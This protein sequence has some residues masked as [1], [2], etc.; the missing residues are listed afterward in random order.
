[1]VQD[2]NQRAAKDKHNEA[3]QAL[4]QLRETPRAGCEAGEE[5]CDVCRGDEVEEEEG[6]E[7]EGEEE[8][9]E[10]TEAAEADKS[11][12]EEMRRAFEQQQRERQAPQ[13]TLTQH[14]QQE[15]GDVE[16]LRRQLAQWA[17]RCGVCEGAGEGSSAHNVRQ[18]WRV[19]SRQV[20]ET[21]KAIEEEIK[22]D[23]WTGCWWCGV[24]QEICH[25]WE[26]NGRRGYQRAKAG[27]CQYRGV[28][29][30]ALIGIA[31]G[32]R[33]IGSQWHGR[34]QAVGVDDAGLGRSVVEYLG[35]KRVLETVE[36]NQLVG[37]FC[38][39]TRLLAE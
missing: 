31:L 2:G 37:E 6:E 1:M 4:V 14:R 17:N 25:R 33:E 30:G 3:D 39:I 28:L 20:K 36:S 18:C 32:Y 5:R 22:F 15:F 9:I 8:G 13:Q 10:E 38:W 12:G 7:E 26:S 24:P 21:I 11:E 29:M 27:N 16:W 35:K 19:E 23:K 34:L